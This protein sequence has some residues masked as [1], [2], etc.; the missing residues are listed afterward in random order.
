MCCNHTV[1]SVDMARRTSL[2]LAGEVALDARLRTETVAVAFAIAWGPAPV[3][4]QAPSAP[5]P[6][7]EP[8]AVPALV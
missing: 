1:Y 4:P 3:A 2:R 5:S 7:T 6:I 8:T